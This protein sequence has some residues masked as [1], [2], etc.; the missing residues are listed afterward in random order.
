MIGAAS[1]AVG[2]AWLLG[3]GMAAIVWPRATPLPWLAWLAIG[4]LAG[5]CVAGAAAMLLGLMGL[6]PSAALLIITS[7]A[8]ALVGVGWRRT[9]RVP[10]EFRLAGDRA[11]LLTVVVAVATTGMVALRTHLGWDGTVVWLHRARM[12]T[13]SQGVMRP[14]T[15]AS[16][17]RS[18]SRTKRRDCV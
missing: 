1:A 11:L 9:C 12:L 13:A 5:P 4:G 8:V 15:M 16:T 10:G 18:R 17:K 3:L 14:S 6:A 7:I 2:V